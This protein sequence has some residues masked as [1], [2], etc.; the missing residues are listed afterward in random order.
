MTA[1]RRVEPEPLDRLIARAAE[2]EHALIGLGMPRCP[3]CMLLS[4]SLTAIARA[5]PGLVVGTSMFDGPEDWERRAELLWP[6]DIHVSRSSV[7][8]LVLL[9]RGRPVASLRGGAPAHRLDAW[10]QE[11]LG[12]AEY[13]LP[14]GRDPG[15]QRTLDE[16]S[17][18]RAQ[19]RLVKERGLPGSS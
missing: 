15:E 13:P 6:R 3:A 14:A 11:Y 16:L 18:R 19:H 12:P 1:A 9:A 8:L 5:R 4:P 7:P 2:A 17:A 10:L